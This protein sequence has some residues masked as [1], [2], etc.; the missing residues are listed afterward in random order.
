MGAF[1]ILAFMAV[2]A[3]L[4][5][6]AVLAVLAVF[7]VLALINYLIDCPS[8]ARPSDPIAAAD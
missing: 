7:A 8:L 2:L 3:V 5:V 6:M 1:S 4:A